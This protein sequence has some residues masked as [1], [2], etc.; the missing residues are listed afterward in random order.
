MT[1]TEN[2]TCKECGLPIKLCNAIALYRYSVERFE[3]GQ[4]EAA[5]DFATSAERHYRDWR[6][7]THSQ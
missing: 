2:Q 3:Q 4:L 1:Q 6:S 7:S 5:K